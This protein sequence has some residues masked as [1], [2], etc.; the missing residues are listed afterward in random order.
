MAKSSTIF[1]AVLFLFLLWS[2]EKQ[3]PVCT[4]NC[5]SITANGK[6]I[7][8]LS[9]DGA[10]NI[11]VTLQWQRFVGLAQ[12]QL[13]IESVM[14]SEAGEFDF[15]ANIDTAY[16]R[17]GYELGLKVRSGGDYIILGSTGKI[18]AR[19]YEYDTS[20]FHGITFDVFRKAKLIIRLHRV[21]TDDFK[22][23]VISHGVFGGTNGY[24]YSVSSPKEV[25][26]RNQYELNVNTVSDVYTKIKVE[27][28]AI[29]GTA[30]VRV[31][32]VRC[33]ASGTTYFD[34]NF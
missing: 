32:S 27:K 9:G 3:A 30:N 34:V 23:F 18:D 7:N 6:V 31:D 14:S 29:N 33:S 11:P 13:V 25:I 26:D 21:Q 17:K 1:T 28:I 5:A 2:C 20:A 10:A 22:N 19:A 4:G 16:F 8:N 12:E 15:S 24:D